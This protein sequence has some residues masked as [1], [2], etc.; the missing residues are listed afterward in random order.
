MPDVR[1][2]HPSIRGVARSR[3]EGKHLVS[4]RS[5]TVAPDAA[6]RQRP[7]RD[8]GIATALPTRMCSPR[9]LAHFVALEHL[10]PV[11]VFTKRTFRGPLLGRHR[12]PSHRLLLRSSTA[13]VV[14]RHPW[15]GGI[16]EGSEM[17]HHK[18]QDRAHSSAQ[19]SGTAP[20]VTSATTRSTAASRYSG[21][22]VPPHLTPACSGLAALAADARR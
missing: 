18:N 21:T 22:V 19:H 3:G 4:F 11:P 8:R 15:C 17:G 5:R 20:G 13:G 16:A 1:W 6:V 10:G 14:G 7:G 12:L 9:H 2:G